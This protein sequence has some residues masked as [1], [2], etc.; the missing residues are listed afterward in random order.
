MKP[1]PNPAETGAHM[2]GLLI[3]FAGL[4]IILAVCFVCSLVSNCST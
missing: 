2:L 3:P 1:E 4:I